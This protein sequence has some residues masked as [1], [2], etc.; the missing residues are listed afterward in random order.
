MKYNLNYS[1]IQ[2]HP[3]QNGKKQNQKSRKQ[4]TNPSKDVR[5][6]DPY[7]KSAEL[8]GLTSTYGGRTEWTPSGCPLAR[9]L[10]C[11]MHMDTYTHTSN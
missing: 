4:T 8:S 7:C 10:C 9:Q 2:S 1:D 3:N 5:E 11:S 6:K